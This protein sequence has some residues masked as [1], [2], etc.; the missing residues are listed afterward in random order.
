M[1]A[2]LE[3]TG[4]SMRVLIVFCHPASDSYV[5]SLAGAL[6]RENAGTL[7]VALGR[8]PNAAELYAAHLLGPDQAIL[9]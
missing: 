3:E 2:R 1:P 6:S 4:L 5:A 9:L 7:R 8:W